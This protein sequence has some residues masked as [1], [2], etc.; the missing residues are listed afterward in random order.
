MASY[1][2]IGSAGGA[3]NAGAL[4]GAQTRAEVLR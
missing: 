3:S 2:P 1:L 4:K